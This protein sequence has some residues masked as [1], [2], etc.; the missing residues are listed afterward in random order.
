MY[1]DT[2]LGKGIVLDFRLRACKTVGQERCVIIGSNT[3]FAEVLMVLHTPQTTTLQTNRL[4]SQA[5]EKSRSETRHLRRAWDPFFFRTMCFDASTK[6]AICQ[7]SI[8][9][10][11]QIN[12]ALKEDFPHFLGRK[13]HPQVN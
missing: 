12:A 7:P 6:L 9:S 10:W 8:P 3:F 4:E 5:K 11:G 13:I 1:T 2:S